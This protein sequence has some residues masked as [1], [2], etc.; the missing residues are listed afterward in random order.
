M[1]KMTY[2]QAFHFLRQA[3]LVEAEID[4]LYQFRRVYQMSELDQPSL[5]LSRLQFIRWLVATGRLTEQLPE[6]RRAA[7]SS[8]HDMKRTHL[9]TLARFSFL[10][11][12]KG[13]NPIDERSDPF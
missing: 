10:L 2:Q 7:S 11:F 13:V 6:T 9:S 4:R 12:S 5:D 1:N 3:G 8:S